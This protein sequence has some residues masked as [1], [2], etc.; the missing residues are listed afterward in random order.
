MKPIKTALL[1]ALVLASSACT[2]GKIEP[3]HVGVVVPLSGTEK[4]ELKTI[5]NGWYAYSFNTQVFEFP[6]YKQNHNWTA[7]KSEGKLNTDERLYF[8]D[9]RGQKV[10]A[11]VGIQYSV[12]AG[13]VTK[14]FT[15]YR[16]PLEQVQD[17]VLKMEVRNA[18][19]RAAQQYDAEDMFGDKRAAFF[20]DALARVQASVGPNGI[21]V[22]NLYLNGE[23]ELP[24][25][26]ATTITAQLQGKMTAQQKVNEKLAVEAEAAKTVAQAEGEAKART[27]KAQG[28]AN[29]RVA[30][31]K[32]EADA[33]L[34]QAEAQAKANEILNRS[35]SGSI[36]EVR[37]LEIQADVQKAYAEKWQGGVPSQILPSQVGGYMMDMRGMQAAPK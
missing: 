26:I 23:L 28:E 5:Q 6:T 11:D 9:K 12:P 19:N 2:F 27:A 16:Q 21:E 25:A 35:L 30:G 8:M 4:G 13:N 34:V 18:L 20:D 37:K 33:I 10:G 14:L 17:T 1:A 24:P 31:A 32:G 7:S 15:T 29:A 36:L 22:T 3:G